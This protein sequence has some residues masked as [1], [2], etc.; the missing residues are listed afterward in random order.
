MAAE[1]NRLADK[2][3]RIKRLSGFCIQN[4][5]VKVAT[6]SGNRGEVEAAKEMYRT[7]HY[8]AAL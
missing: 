4:S 6:G 2:A 8:F 3:A 7:I 1:G 5:W